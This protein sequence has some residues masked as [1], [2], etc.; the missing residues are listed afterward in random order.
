MRSSSPKWA[1]NSN[2]AVESEEPD[3]NRPT[4]DAEKDESDDD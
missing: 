3:K 4:P 2:P 1:Y